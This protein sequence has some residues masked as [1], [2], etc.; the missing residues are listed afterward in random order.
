MTGGSWSRK[1]M[2]RSVGSAWDG[3]KWSIFSMDETGANY[4]GL[5][6]DADHRRFGSWGEW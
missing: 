4:D 6:S 3:A 5:T 2:E 1:K